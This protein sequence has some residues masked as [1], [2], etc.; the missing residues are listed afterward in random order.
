MIDKNAVAVHDRRRAGRRAE[1]R[2]RR[3][4][5]P[6]GRHQRRCQRHAPVGDSRHGGG[7]AG[8]SDPHHASPRRRP[9]V[10]GRFRRDRPGQC[11]AVNFS[12]PVTSGIVTFSST[13]G[14][15]V[16]CAAADAAAA[17]LLAPAALVFRA[18]DHRPACAYRARSV[19]HRA[20]A[21]AGHRRRQHHRRRQRQDAA[22]DRAR[23][24]ELRP[25]GW[26]PRHRQPR[27][28]RDATVAPRAV[29]VDDDPDVVGDEPLLLARD[30]LAGVD[31][32]AIGLRARARCSRRIPSAIV[33]IADDGL[34]H[35]ALRARC[36]NRGDR[37]GARARA[38]AAAARRTVARAGVAPARASTPSCSSAATGRRPSASS[39]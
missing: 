17:V 13:S 3:R 23:A 22:D 24:S 2:R 5:G 20:P 31:R 18:G 12:E 8:R 1:T 39:R 29:G 27:L 4:Q 9:Q 10:A 7:A 37:R 33:I 14:R 11:P 34:Q 6:G 16:V 21:G 30:R 25:R 32:R 15:R 26:Q 35:Y 38:T 36:R 28:R 19:P